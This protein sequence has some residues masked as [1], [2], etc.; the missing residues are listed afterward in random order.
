[1]TT[2]PRSHHS[3]ETQGPVCVVRAGLY[4]MHRMDSI[5]CTVCAARSVNTWVLCTL[6]CEHC[7]NA[8]CLCGISMYSTLLSYC[9]YYIGY[10]DE[11]V[12]CILLCILGTLYCM[13]CIVCIMHD[14][15]VY[16]H[17]TFPI[18][19]LNSFP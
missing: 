11:G 5:V 2:C 9:I 17:V 13:P 1:M 18:P 15:C 10:C 8:V 4:I 14:A 12:E 3:M 6:K 16:R 19:I 7:M